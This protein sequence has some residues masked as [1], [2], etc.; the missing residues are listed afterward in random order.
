[1]S[2]ILVDDTADWF[3]AAKDWS[4]FIQIGEWTTARHTDITT[5]QR[6]CVDLSDG[7]IYSIHG[8]LD[9]IK[10]AEQSVLEMV[11]E[12]PGTQQGK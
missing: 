9:D 12:H 2:D 6:I 10:G 1:M 5:V 3:L 7:S 4:N 11:P 8:E